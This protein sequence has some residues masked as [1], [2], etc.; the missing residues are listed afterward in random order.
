MSWSQT[1]VALFCE[2]FEETN[3]VALT[4][5]ELLAFA[6]RHERPLLAVQGGS[7]R[8]PSQD[9]SV[10]RIELPRG[11]ASFGIEHDLRYDVLLWRH[12]P[13]V[14]RA[15]WRFR[16]D[17]IHVVSPGEFGQLGAW[18]AHVLRIPL[19]ASWHTNLHQF[20]GRR[21]KTL[22]G[23]LPGAVAANLG[24][25]SENVALAT[26]LKFYGIARVLLAPTTEQV[27][28]LHEATGRPCF[29]MS[30]GVDR[31]Q[32]HPAKRTVAD[33][34][35]RLGYVGRITPEKGVRLF[36]E[37]ERA[38]LSAGHRD[39]QIVVVGEGS[40]REWLMQ[41][42]THGV[43]PGVLRG[44]QL[45]QAYANMDL[46][47][48]PSR[49]DT[50]GNVIQEAA[51]SGVPSIVTSE[52]GPQHLVTHG[53]TGVVARTDGEFVA[54]IVDL[55]SVAEQLRA[56]GRCSLE[57]VR[58]ASTWDAAFEMTYAA[59]RYARKNTPGAPLAKPNVKRAPAM[60][61]SSSRA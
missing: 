10:T 59:Y 23:F 5:R 45:A 24:R 40:E 3:G 17:V 4:A 35:L 6:K 61:P 41:N 56:M 19:V 12:L 9:G 30:R 34:T 8:S 58:T 33:T 22:L 16:P 27:T 20:A 52:G 32:F 18:L 43:F 38:L 31:Q 48:F 55:L 46:F 50:F 44:E 15:L 2:T 25:I 21:L 13:Y 47:V 29:L 49:T 39:F 7:R 57:R 28:W 53:V 54:S 60:S 42:L 26:L 51:A 36:L 1:R 14:R 37:I 11:W